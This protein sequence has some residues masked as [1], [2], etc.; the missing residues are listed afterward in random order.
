MKFEVL[1]LSSGLQIGGPG[2]SLACNLGVIVHQF[3]IASNPLVVFRVANW[4]P[5][6]QVFAIEQ[7]LGLAP[8]LRHRTV[9]L[10]R[11]NSGESRSL[12]VA[13]S[14]DSAQ[15]IFSC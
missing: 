12:R 6:G 13:A 1:K 4:L 7:G 8:R 2:T 9:E 14:F 15:L 3:S 11:A 5:T 10:R